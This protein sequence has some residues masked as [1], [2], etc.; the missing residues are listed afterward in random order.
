MSGGLG[1]TGDARGGR[2]IVWY[3][4]RRVS[5][6]QGSEEY[7]LLLRTR[8][9]TA[10]SAASENGNETARGVEGGRVSLRVITQKP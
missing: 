6:V 1:R 4:R 5:R 9:R 10:A 8:Q 7:L 3:D 2:G